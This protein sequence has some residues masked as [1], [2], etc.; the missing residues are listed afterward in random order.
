MWRG[1]LGTRRPCAF[2]SHRWLDEHGHH[3][4]AFLCLF[5]SECVQ[6]LISR[7]GVA[8][9]PVP[10]WSRIKGINRFLMAGVHLWTTKPWMAPELH[11][12]TPCP[13]KTYSNTMPHLCILLIFYRSLLVRLFFL[14]S[15]VGENDDEHPAGSPKSVDYGVEELKRAFEEWSKCLFPQ[16]SRQETAYQP[17]RKERL[18]FFNVSSFGNKKEKDP[19]SSG[20]QRQHSCSKTLSDFDLLHLRLIITHLPIYKILQTSSRCVL[21]SEWKVHKAPN[22]YVNLLHTFCCFKIFFIHAVYMCTGTACVY[23]CMVALFGS[24]I[25]GLCSRNTCAYLLYL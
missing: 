14:E 24:S 22:I 15:I 3:G 20:L 21:S 2:S 10:Q 8:N 1:L 5:V 16:Q 25:I 7:V 17:S 19:P 13:Q 18:P 6:K 9:F 4:D 11:G 23:L 12:N